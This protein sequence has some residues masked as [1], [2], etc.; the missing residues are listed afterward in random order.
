[1]VFVQNKQVFFAFNSKRRGFWRG[2][3]LICRCF[4]VLCIK[5]LSRGVSIGSI[6]CG[7]RIL[8]K[9]EC[10]EDEKNHQYCV[11][12]FCVVICTGVVWRL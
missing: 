2:K 1:V 3:Y 12:H 11:G 5:G 7:N 9:G 4:L 6:T 8:D 10:Y